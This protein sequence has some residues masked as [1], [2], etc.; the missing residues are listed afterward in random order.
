MNRRKVTYRVTATTLTLLAALVT[1]VTSCSA[2][3]A[4]R[5]RVTYK[6]TGTAA[7]ATA[8]G[9]SHASTSAPAGAGVDTATQARAD[10]Q[11]L[12]VVARRPYVPGYQRSCNPGQACSFGAAWTDDQ[13]A[14]DGHNGCS[15]RDDVLAAQLRNVTRRA[16]SRCVVV[17][18]T[19]SDPYTGAT[20]TFSKSEADLVPLDHVVPLEL[21]WDLGAAQWSQAERVEFANDPTIELLAVDEHSNEQKSANGPADWMPP[22]RSYWCT[23][24]ARFVTVLTR[25]RLSVT[26]ADKAAMIAVLAHC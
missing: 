4:D 22:N 8:P 12:V 15:T 26:I 23:Y 11:R 6:V 1:L 5:A 14:V 7:S 13:D 3:T 9:A 25:Y 10:L 24:D 17:A 19:L 2:T 20:I 21:A 16:G 18:G